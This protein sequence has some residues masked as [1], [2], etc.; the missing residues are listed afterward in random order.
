MIRVGAFM[1]Y[2]KLRRA[3]NS[4]VVTIPKDQIDEQNLEEGQLLAVHVQRAEVRP[5]LSEAA[6]KAF[7][8]SWRENE[9]G[10]RYLAG[11]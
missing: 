1:F 4:Y 3:G 9:A 10:Y 5:V 6:R 11:R 7:E 8:D 2:G